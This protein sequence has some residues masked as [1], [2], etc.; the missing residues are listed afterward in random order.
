MRGQRERLPYTYG[1]TIKRFKI[2]ALA[3]GV[4]ALIGLTWGLVVV[5]AKILEEAR[6]GR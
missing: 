3:T 1:M 5:N 2:C 4:T 6:E